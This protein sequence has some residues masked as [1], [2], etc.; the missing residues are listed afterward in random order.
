MSHCCVSSRKSFKWRES[1]KLLSFHHFSIDQRLT[2]G[3]Y[4]RVLEPISKTEANLTVQPLPSYRLTV[5]HN[6]TGKGVTCFW[7]VNAKFG[8][9]LFKPG[10]KTQMDV[11]KFSS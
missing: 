8:A 1:D 3:S 6:T 9:H 10:R 7:H 5:L 2:F 4:F 11:I